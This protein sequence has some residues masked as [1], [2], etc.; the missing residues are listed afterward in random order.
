MT[1]TTS[2]TSITINEFCDMNSISRSMFYKLLKQG[3]A[4]NIMKVGSK[5]LIS[6]E[7]ATAWRNA[8]E[9]KG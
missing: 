6:N 8:M 3:A 1:S 7:A 2:K 5:T 4:P 9:N